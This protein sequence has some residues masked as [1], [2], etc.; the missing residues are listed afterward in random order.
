MCSPVERE[1]DV[2]DENGA[3]RKF[4]T[5]RMRDDR[6]ERREDREK[7]DEKDGGGEG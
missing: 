5:G 3:W 4:L 6:G 1:I 7:K 2:E